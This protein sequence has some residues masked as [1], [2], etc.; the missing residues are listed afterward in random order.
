MPSAFAIEVTNA[1]NLNC[2]MCSRRRMKRDVGY[3]DFSLFKKIL[4]EIGKYTDFF[5]LH[6]LGEPLLHPEI[7]K[8]IKYAKKKGIKVGLSTNAVLLNQEIGDRILNAGIDK[9]ILALDSITSDTYSKIRVGGLFDKV[10]KNIERFIERKKDGKY[11][12]HIILQAIQMKENENEV[13]D[14]KRYWKGK[15]VDEIA[16]AKLSTWAGQVEEM[17]YLVEE[18]FKYRKSLNKRPP[19]EYL[20]YSVVILWDGRVV[21]CCIDFDAKLCLGDLKRESLRKI[22]NGRK[23]KELRRSHM[24]NIFPS[25]CKNCIEYPFTSHFPSLFSM[26]KNV[27]FRIRE[28]LFKNL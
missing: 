1:C 5:W 10:V 6:E 9:I 26:C 8:F 14:F 4:K 12:S 16:I 11:S 20:W 25:I 2:A 24:K 3:M 28:F 17:G 19:C 21:P 22:W 7:D 13:E 23:I 27:Y 18:R 15:G